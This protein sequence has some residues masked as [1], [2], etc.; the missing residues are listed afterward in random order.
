MHMIS[1]ELGE[2]DDTTA[3]AEEYRRRIQELHLDEE[4]EK[5]LL[6]EVDRLAKMQSSNQEGTVI[7][8]Y[9]D[10]CLDLPW[11]SFTE[12]DLDIAKAQRILDRDH[13]GLKLS[14]IH[15]W[16]WLILSVTIPRWCRPFRRLTPTPISS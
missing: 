13:Y 2:D 5:K 14:L 10:T 3:E 6:K 12:D 11:N 9:L 8:T 4:R 15:I 1:Q 7:R 16:R